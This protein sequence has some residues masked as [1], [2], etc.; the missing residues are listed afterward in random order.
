MPYKDKEKEREHRK[1][2]YSENKELHKK[3]MS[4][5]YKANKEKQSIKRSEYYL[6]NKERILE[7]G[8]RHYREN[9][10]MYAATHRA[11]RKK[12]WSW[13]K[14]IKLGAKCGKCGESDPICL[15]FHHIDPSKKEHNIGHLYSNS[16]SKELVLR[17]VSKCIVLC[18]N[19]H[20]KE[21]ARLKEEK[22]RSHND[23]DT[24]KS[25]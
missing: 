15:D 1:K 23:H 2:Y 11:Y 3:R 4:D 22:L 10:E 7:N 16:A 5:W 12:A 19:C 21:H 17:E 8:K 18:S 13:L 24:R 14:D 9:K 6:K 20:R 25:S